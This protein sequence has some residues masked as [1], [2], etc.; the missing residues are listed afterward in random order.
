MTIDEAKL[1][2]LKAARAKDWDNV[3]KLMPELTSDAIF[4]VTASAAEALLDA[5]HAAPGKRL[6]D[7]AMG[8]GL[9]VPAIQRRGVELV[10]LD[11]AP[12]MVE[13]A[14]R[15]FPELK[16]VLG[17]AENL[18]FPDATFDAVICNFGINGFPQPERA[19]A[20]ALRVVRPGGHHAFTTWCEHEG[21][22]LF[23][24]ARDAIRRHIELPPDGGQKRAWRPDEAGEL[25]R[26]AGFVDVRAEVIR[27][28]ARPRTSREVLDLVYTTGRLLRVVSAQDAPTRQRIEAEI[29]E[30]TRRYDRG[31]GIELAMP[32]VLARGTKR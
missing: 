4:G 6:L 3:A 25:L 20:E 18:D 19:L 31:H 1:G 11:F 5:V 28:A 27:L 26:Q 7:V 24:L 15:R 22:D 29:V 14:R 32:T 13:E 16:V 10:G 21:N 30:Q 23:E 8:P 17:D 12:T 9:V 2:S